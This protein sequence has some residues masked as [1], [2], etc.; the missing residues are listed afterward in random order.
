VTTRLYATAALGTADLVAAELKRLGF[1][2]V[3]YDAGGA[4][5]D[6]DDPPLQAA[7]R[8]CLHLRAALRV[9][10]PLATFPVV[11]LYERT[12]A[13]EWERFLTPQTT[14][15]VSATTSAPPPHAHA[16]Y[17]GQRMK[18]AVVDRLRAR[19]G[20][21]PD[22]DRD[23]PDVRL[24]VHV[25]KDGAASVGVD[26]SGTSLHERGY[27]VA[28]T[29]A[30]LRETLAAAALLA[31]DFKGDRPLVD[32]MCGSGTLAIEAARL[33][34]RVPPG[35]SRRFGFERWPSF[36]DAER[37]AWR[38]LQD[39]AR[40]AILPRA[41]QPI[42][43]SDR[44]DDALAAAR[45]NV[46]AAGVAADVT[47]R[48]ADVRELAPLDP[49]GVV[50]SNPPY[51]ERLGA[52]SGPGLDAFWRGLGITLRKLDGHTAFLFVPSPRMIKL[53][54]MRPSWERKL[55]NG[56]I[57]VSLCRFELGRQRTATAESRRPARRR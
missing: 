11:E 39:A 8:A 15:A 26:P 20:A 51:G 49:P 12:A 28:Q 17:L 14:F 22:V 35:L 46:A 10:W 37:A 41:P 13:V 54:G 3:R 38:E 16:P 32:P 52:E 42:F 1:P 43:A 40:A 53:L 25:D 56:A 36:G 57:P 44:D 31:A 23:D 45:A 27:R 30:P 2:R 18:D 50:L 7:M 55:R 47:L 21:R 24:Y 6:S 19:A 29:P 34:R 9:L 33:V 5:F 4:L 48:L